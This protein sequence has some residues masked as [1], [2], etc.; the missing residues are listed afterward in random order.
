MT[1]LVIFDLDGTLIDSSQDIANAINHAIQ[2][3]GLPEIS[4]EETIMLIG[5][6]ITRLVEKLLVPHL[7][8]KKDVIL[9][10]F[11]RYYSSH[12]VDTTTLYPFVKETLNG[13]DNIRKVILSNKRASFS[14]EILDKLGVSEYFDAIYGSDTAEEKKPSPIPVNMLLDRFSVSKDMAV[15]VGDSDT[16]IKTA[17]AAGIRSIGV[18]YGYRD[19]ETLKEA[20]RLIDDLRQLK[21]VIDEML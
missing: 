6:G 17:R 1:K 9:N 14:A 8:D 5:E 2:G 11:L 4:N 15:L 20:D 3:T 7:L 16:D 19:K 12:L 10:R 13:L 18:T 21:Q